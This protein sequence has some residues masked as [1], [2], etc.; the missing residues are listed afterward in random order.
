MRTLPLRRACFVI[1]ACLR[2]HVDLAEKRMINFE[3]QAD[4]MLGEMRQ[5]IFSR[6]DFIAAVTSKC[7]LVSVEGSNPCPRL[8]RVDEGVIRVGTP[9]KLSHYR[10]KAMDSLRRKL[11]KPKTQE[12][13]HYYRVRFL[14]AHDMSAAV[15]GPHG[16]GYIVDSGENWQ[17]WLRKCLPLVQVSVDR[18]KYVP[19]RRFFGRPLNRPSRCEDP[20]NLFLSL[21]AVGRHR[22]YA[23][24]KLPL[25]FIAPSK[26]LPTAHRLVS[27]IHVLCMR[28]SFYFSLQVS[29]WL[30]R[31]GVSAVTRADIL[32]VDEMIDKLREV[33]GEEAAAYIEAIDLKSF[34]ARNGGLSSRAA[35]QKEVFDQAYAELALFVEEQERSIVAKARELGVDEAATAGGGLASGNPS[36]ARPAASTAPMSTVGWAGKRSFEGDMVLESR[37]R[38]TEPPQWAWVRRVNLEKWKRFES[39][40]A[41]PAA[42]PAQPAGPET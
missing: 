25:S 30:V 23:R 18:H 13:K 9:A 14:C 8:I 35:K 42:Q 17:R 24:R 37:Q 26:V 4:T 10:R 38:G 5:G 3:R 32:P 16:E 6:L 12:S 31:V 1:A 33:A 15:C 7:L 20:L 34:D 39:P 2:D 27:W 36:G 22:Q 19:Y 41:T 29:L 40:G 28:V 11:G 21:S